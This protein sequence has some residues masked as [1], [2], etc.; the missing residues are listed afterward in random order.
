MF[1]MFLIRV[2][3]RDGCKIVLPLFCVNSITSIYNVI[4]DFFWTTEKKNSPVNSSLV[5]CT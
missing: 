4:S 1:N 3:N 2:P 5:Y